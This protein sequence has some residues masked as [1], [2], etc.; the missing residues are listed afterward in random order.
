MKSNV[1]SRFIG[2]F[3]A[4]LPVKLFPMLGTQNS[5]RIPLLWLLLPEINVQ[6]ILLVSFMVPL[7][8]EE[9]TGRHGFLAC[10]GYDSYMVYAKTNNSRCL[11]RKFNMM[12][13]NFVSSQ[14]LSRAD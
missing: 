14:L 13:F 11:R 7:H 4:P 6:H 1:S 10:C 9:E 2:T 12:L 8:L 5:F 3:N